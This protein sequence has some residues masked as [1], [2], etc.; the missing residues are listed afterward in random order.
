MK[1]RC[2]TSFI[3]IIIACVLFIS[4]CAGKTNTPDVYIDEKKP[5]VVLSLFTQGTNISDAIHE[6]CTNIINPKNDGNI[7][8]YSDS[9]SYYSEDGLPYRELL[10]RRM[11]SGQAD[12]LY[13]ITAE[14]VLEFDQKG[15]IY[16]L[17]DLPC[18]ENLSG[19]A[20]QQSIYHGKVFSV[21]LSYAGFGLIWNVD[22][23]LYT[24]PPDGF[25]TRKI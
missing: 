4:G 21:P 20:L 22:C 18:L 24:S 8:L 5:D 3:S 16:D 19:D 17:S 14:D 11:E 12:D 6:C 1:R 9:A 2:K 23:L 25:T 10:L 15:Y 7:I 13:I